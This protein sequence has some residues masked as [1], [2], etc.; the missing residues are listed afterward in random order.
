MTPPE[1][2]AHDKLLQAFGDRPF[3]R[4][5]ALAVVGEDLLTALAAGGMIDLLEGR[6]K[7]AREF[8]ELETELR[9]EAE[10]DAKVAWLERLPLLRHGREML[11]LCG[12]NSC[13]SEL[14]RG[15]AAISGAPW[16]DAAGV[17]IK[18]V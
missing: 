9:A 1:A 7:Y 15:A 14:R 4:A 13:A 6:L 18:R 17:K 2:I 11:E 3:R 5:E 12:E 16:P 10:S 8:L